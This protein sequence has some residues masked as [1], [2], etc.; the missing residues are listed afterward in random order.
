MK[1]ILLS[2]LIAAQA[3]AARTRLLRTPTVSVTQIAFAYANNIWTVDR[4]GGAARRLT[5]FQGLS[6]N[7]HFSPDGRWI[8]FSA[9]YG[10]NLDVYVMLAEGGEP[11]R[12]TWHPG[13]DTVQGWTADGK[14]ILFTSTRASASPTATARFWTVPAQG[15]VE[16]PLALPRGYQGK[17]SATGS[18]IAHPLNSPWDSPTATARFWTVP[19]QGGVEEPLALPRGYQ[20]KISATGSHIAYRMN[21]S[22]DEERRNYRGGQNRP[23]WIVNLST[24]D[25][26]SPPWTDSKDM[27][28][29]WVGDTVYFISDRDGV[30]N[31][32]SYETKSK[33]LTQLTKFKDFDVKSLDSGAGTVV[34]EQAGY[35]HE[36]DPKSGKTHIV[37]ITASGDFPWMMPRWQDV[38][39]RMTGL[40]I[41]PTG[42]RVAVEARGE[43]FTMPAEKGDVR[44][45]T[46][47]SGSTEENPA[48][49]P[50]G[51]FVSWFGD[52]CGEF[53]L[54]IQARD[55]LTPPRAIDLP[56]PSRYYPPSWSPD[57]KKILY[58]DTNLRVWVLDVATGKT[59]Q[60]GAD[61]WMVPT[62]TLNPVWSPDSK[63]V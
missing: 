29:A 40:T 21:S 47:S 14:S 8:A 45:L 19:A 32:W 38:T 6:G 35:I 52:K 31:V 49:S 9:E 59:R 17:I 7:P 26:V 61:P 55:G 48:W 30:A 57:S 50:D 56:K 34:F 5:S 18:H 54:F 1:T 16:E 22:W 28:P 23:I 33:K 27:D 2:L 3:G 10:G 37:D 39:S 63:W 25:L 42:R 4:A 13:P 51:K 53:E 36:L 12:L 15:G 44:N 20:G 41:S 24:Y 11:K 43:I 58:S 62:R 60:L 46:H